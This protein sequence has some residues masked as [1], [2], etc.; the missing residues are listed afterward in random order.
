MYLHIFS[1]SK[2]EQITRVEPAMVEDVRKM[3]ADIQ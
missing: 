2:I 3:V 1:G